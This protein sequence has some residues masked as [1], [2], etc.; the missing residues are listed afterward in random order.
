MPKYYD[1]IT[2][3]GVIVPDTSTVLSDIQQEFMEVFGN[4]LD[5]SAT[6]PQGRLIEMLQRNRSFCIQICALV[7]NM[8][9]L[10]RA[11]GFV[12]DDL[13]SLFL[14]QRQPATHTQTAVNL[15]GVAGTII[16]QGTRLQ[17]EAGDIFESMFETTIGSD[18]TVTVEFQSKETGAIPCVVNTL[19]IILDRISGLE[20]ANNPSAA[21]LGHDLESDA[22]YRTRIKDSL[23]INSIAI[24]SAIQANLENVSGVIDSYCYDN[25]TDSSAVIDS[26]TV[27][28]HSILAC[29]EGGT[30]LDVAQVLYKKKT[31]GTGYIQSATNL[32]SVDVIDEAYGTT[33]NVKFMRPIT[34]N[35]DV[36]VYLNKQGYSGADLVNAVKDAVLQWY[37]GSIDGVDGVRIGKDVSPFEIGAAVSYVLPDIFITSVKIAA[38]GST[39]TTNVM[40]INKVH[41]ALL[42]RANIKVSIDGGAL[43]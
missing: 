35:M 7:S 28:P 21:S 26:V 42:S 18:G 6:T 10:G 19:N 17:T 38:H 37:D 3:Q 27:P 8:L 5:L 14:I 25:S 36:E 39:P 4:D 29:V 41:K 32:V 34:T 11:S 23:N 12:L 40:T 2:G 24:L 20:T 31:I 9:N 16:P 15:T 22:T 33:Y 1:Y 30:D 43:Q 13:G